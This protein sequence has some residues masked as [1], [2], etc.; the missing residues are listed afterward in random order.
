[1]A[2]DSRCHATSLRWSLER[3][4]RDPRLLDYVSLAVPRGF[5]RPGAVAPGARVEVYGAAGVPGA[6]GDAAREAVRDAD[7]RRARRV[8]AAAR[9]RA[10]ARA[11]RSA[12][13][14]SLWLVAVDGRE[15]DGDH[16]KRGAS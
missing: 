1:M 16:A 3:L 5:V 13:R 11:A 12:A 4:G 15:S 8:R 10:S 9:A 6:D 2:S 14:R 7:R